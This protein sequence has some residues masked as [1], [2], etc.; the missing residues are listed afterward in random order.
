[1]RKVLMLCSFPEPPNASTARAMTR[2]T[3]LIRSGTEWSTKFDGF[4]NSENGLQ[5]QLP[6]VEDDAEEEL[7]PYGDEDEGFAI[8]PLSK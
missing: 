2:F 5:H 4:Q 6:S 3:P 8:R 1:M 7:H